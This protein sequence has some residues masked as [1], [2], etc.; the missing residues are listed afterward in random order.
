MLL[1]PELIAE[2]MSSKIRT[3]YHN[4][5][6]LLEAIFWLGF[7]RFVMVALPFRWIAPYLGQRMA[8]TPTDRVS[9][10]HLQQLQK[11]SWAI[12]KLS[13][14]TPWQSKCLVQ[15]IA[16]KRMLQ[17]R[18]INSTLYLGVIRNDYR[19]Q[20]NSDPLKAHAWLRSG[21]FLLTGGQGY[22]QFTVVAT[23]AEVPG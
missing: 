23:F 14:H 10:E 22:Q 2:L 13:P 20:S 15:A 18:Q 19:D 17:L 12:R 21:R 7:S 6:V 11:I 5:Y 1:T 8:E 4:R 3:A 9:D 16:A